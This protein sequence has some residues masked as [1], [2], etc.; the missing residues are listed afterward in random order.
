MCWE[1]FGSKELDL[2]KQDVERAIDL[3]S[4]PFSRQYALHC[5]FAR[6]SVHMVFVSIQLGLSSIVEDYY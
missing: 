4:P 5:C 1:L 6:L 2:V 3:Q